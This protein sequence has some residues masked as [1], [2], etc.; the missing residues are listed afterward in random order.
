M[1]LLSMQTYTITRIPIYEECE[2]KY[3]TEA[4]RRLFHQTKEQSLQRTP[5]S[6]TD[7]TS[8]PRDFIHAQIYCLVNIGVRETI[9]I[10][11]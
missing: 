4:S 2:K 3:L 8:Y 9:L 11:G 6:V 10:A 7:F 1:L 5:G